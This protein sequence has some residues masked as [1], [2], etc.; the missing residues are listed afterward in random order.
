VLVVGRLTPSGYQ[1]DLIDAGLGMTEEELETA[2]LRISQAGQRRP[3]TK[4]LGHH[5]VGR[6]ASRRGI[7]VRL[8]PSVQTGITAQVLV[9]AAL[10]SNVGVPTAV[11]APPSATTTHPRPPHSGQ[12][13]T[14]A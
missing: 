7:F 1:F 6:I 12:G 4:V 11:P 2:N 3:D 8:L 5:V 10:L 13:S 14:S 9:P